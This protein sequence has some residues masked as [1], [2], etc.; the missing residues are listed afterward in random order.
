MVIINT[1]KTKLDA[2]D[3][4]LLSKIV[5]GYLNVHN[6]RWLRHS[7]AD[8]TEGAAPKQVFD[9]AGLTQTVATPT[10]GETTPYCAAGER[11]LAPYH[12]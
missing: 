4:L 5:L 11:V 2:L 6:K 1:F 12:L 7:I 10:R 9:E 8:S 3:S